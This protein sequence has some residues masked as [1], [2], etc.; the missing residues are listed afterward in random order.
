V[1]A[2]LAEWVKLE[3]MPLSKIKM[4]GCSMPT[5]WTRR[6]RRCHVT[7]NLVRVEQFAKEYKCKAVSSLDEAIADP[8]LHAGDSPT[9]I[10]Y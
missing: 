10:N 6:G 2:E 5:M 9:Y 3:P 7:T 1:F 8:N 4:P